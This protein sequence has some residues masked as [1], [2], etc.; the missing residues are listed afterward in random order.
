MSRLTLFSVNLVELFELS[1]TVPSLTEEIPRLKIVLF[2]EL[3]EALF[4]DLEKI[5]NDGLKDKPVV[6]LKMFGVSADLIP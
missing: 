5:G 6:S 2:F 1:P 4:A 3:V